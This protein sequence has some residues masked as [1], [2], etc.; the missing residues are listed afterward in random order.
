M[1]RLRV[2]SEHC[3][4]PKPPRPQTGPGMLGYLDRCTQ[5]KVMVVLMRISGR[6]I[7]GKKKLKS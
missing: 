2:V 7:S 3:V 1:V 6:K 4:F 5:S